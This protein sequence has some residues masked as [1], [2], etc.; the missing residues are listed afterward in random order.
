MIGPARRQTDRWLTVG[1]I[2]VAAIGWTAFVR[3]LD[4]QSPAAIGY[5]LGALFVTV[6]VVGMIVSLM[7]DW[8]RRR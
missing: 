5:G 7:H 8:G 2:G 1:L 4:V 6:A 3:T